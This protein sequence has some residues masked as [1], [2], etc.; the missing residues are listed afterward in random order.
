MYHIFPGCM[1]DSMALFVTDFKEKC[2]QTKTSGA[3]TVLGADEEESPGVCG[4]EDNH[5][6]ITRVHA[7]LKTQLIMLV[8]LPGVSGLTSTHSLFRGYFSTSTVYHCPG[9]PSHPH[10]RF[11]IYQPGLWIFNCFQ[12]TLQGCMIQCSEH[13]KEDFSLKLLKRKGWK[14]SDGV[15]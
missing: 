15:T 5:K 1:K 9:L 6:D 4:I 10:H 13:Q 2:D 12:S 14:G 3:A 7:P 11:I 8:S